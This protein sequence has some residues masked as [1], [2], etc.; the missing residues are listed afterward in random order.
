MLTW[1]TLIKRIENDNVSD[2]LQLI[3]QL[4]SELKYTYLHTKVKV[5]FDRSRQRALDYST[6]HYKHLTK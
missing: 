6:A 1:E 3:A 5:I 4:L 2:D